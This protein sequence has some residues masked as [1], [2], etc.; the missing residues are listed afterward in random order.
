MPFTDLIDYRLEVQ[1]PDGGPAVTV[2]DPY[3]F[4]PTLGEI[5]LHLF[6]EGRHERLWEVLGAHRRSFTTPDGVVEGVSFAVW[7]PNAQGVSVVGDFNGWDGTRHRCAC[8]APPGSGSCSAR[9]PRRRP[10][11]VPD[12]RRRRLGRE[13]A[14]PL[15]FATEVPPRT[16]SGVF[17]ERLQL[18][19]RRLAGRGARCAIRSSSR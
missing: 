12:P 8:W 14:D 5:D 4:L 11:Q 13:K 3:R 16:A 19:R 10:V 17:T 15:A 6:G 7:A 2:A 1:L 9:C 18:E